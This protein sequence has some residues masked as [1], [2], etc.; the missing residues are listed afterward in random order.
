MRTG[1]DSVH[2]EPQNG[3]PPTTRYDGF[4]L[5]PTYEA[6]VLTGWEVQ[7]TTGP[8]A[9]RHAWLNNRELPE[10][11]RWLTPAIDL[12]FGIVTVRG[13]GGK[14]KLV[15]INVVPRADAEQQNSRTGE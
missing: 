10:L 13:R 1:G 9:G 4:S 12:N 5:N 6:E 11:R 8:F 7:I 3:S 15:A 2:Q 14:K